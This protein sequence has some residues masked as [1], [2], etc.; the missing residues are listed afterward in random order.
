MQ[1]V[2]TADA[3]AIGRDPEVPVLVLEGYIYCRLREA[4]LD[5]V[6][7]EVVALRPESGDDNRSR[8]TLAVLSSNLPSV[9]RD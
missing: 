6:T 8:K 4:V 1:P 3:A 5:G 7:L 9:P 2:E